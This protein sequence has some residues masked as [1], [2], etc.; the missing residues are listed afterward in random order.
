MKDHQKDVYQGRSIYGTA[1]ARALTKKVY[2]RNIDEE[3]KE[4]EVSSITAPNPSP[5]VVDDSSSSIVMPSAY[6]KARRFC[7]A[8]RMVR[9]TYGLRHIY[10]K[11]IWKPKQKEQGLWRTIQIQRL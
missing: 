2:E 8:A 6:R 1:G 4:D 7:R 3:E 5:A 11:R 10:Q 9:S